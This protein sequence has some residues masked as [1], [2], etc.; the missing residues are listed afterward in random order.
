MTTMRKE[1]RDEIRPGDLVQ[2]LPYTA[3]YKEVTTSDP[4]ES[5]IVPGGGRQIPEKN[6][7]SMIV[8]S[9]MKASMPTANVV[10]GITIDDMGWAWTDNVE[11][12]DDS[13]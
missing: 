11:R 13:H 3:L 2:A 8:V 4:G 10:Y 9:S 6:R 7:S 12:I 1:G 5:V